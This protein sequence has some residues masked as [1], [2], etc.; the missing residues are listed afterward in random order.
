MPMRE[1]I[2]TG[3]A[4]CASFFVISLARVGLRAGLGALF[5]LK[6]ARTLAASESEARRSLLKDPAGVYLPQGQQC[7]LHAGVRVAETP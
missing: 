1:A 4:A 7:R 5:V 3:F 6:R 2:T